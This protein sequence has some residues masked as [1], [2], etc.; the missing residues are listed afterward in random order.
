MNATITLAPSI[1]KRLEKV[2]SSHRTAEDIVK[3]AVK[4]Q[5]AYEEH[6]LKEIDAG[7]ADIEAGRVISDD[8]FWQKIG[9]SKHAKK[10]A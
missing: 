5:L 9:Q 3:Q 10:A 7:I 2:A 8:I 6:V 1:I 4:N